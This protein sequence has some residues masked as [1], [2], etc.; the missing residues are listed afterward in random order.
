MPFP[1]LLRLVAPLSKGT[2]P[3]G[4]Q[5]V[6]T[7]PHGRCLE[8]TR[9]HFTWDGRALLRESPAGLLAVP[10]FLHRGSDQ[11]VP[12][13]EETRHFLSLLLLLKPDQSLE[14][15]VRSSGNSFCNL[16]QRAAEEPDIVLPQHCVVKQALGSI[17]QSSRAFC[18]L[19]ALSKPQGSSA[20]P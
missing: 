13:V 17:T 3:P 1:A 16:K 7:G 14:P 2:P 9:G 15:F 18:K 12:Q 11:A 20:Q 5:R 4:Y 10:D 19:Q 8:R 6:A